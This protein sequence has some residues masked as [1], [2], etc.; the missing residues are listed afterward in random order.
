MIEA[1]VATKPKRSKRLEVTMQK[2]MRLLLTDPETAGKAM[3]VLGRL[4]KEGRIS[5]RDLYRILSVPLATTT[6]KAKLIDFVGGKTTLPQF[7]ELIKNAHKGSVPRERVEQVL[8]CERGNF[9]EKLWML[10]LEY[11]APKSLITNLT[12]KRMHA[13]KMPLQ[14]I[15]E[16]NTIK[17]KM[18]KLSHRAVAAKRRGDK[19]E[20]AMRTREMR[21]LQK[22]FID[23]F[24]K[25]I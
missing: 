25:R 15:D 10:A 5:G 23:R 18:H 8:R 7:L 9:Y 3:A 17:W 11:R 1:P 16:A 22:K 20:Q 19:A 13:L 2:S 24:T 6:L 12:I 4:L 21:A 14:L